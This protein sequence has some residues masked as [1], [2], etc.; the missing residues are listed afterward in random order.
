MTC[1][2]L[3]AAP[4]AAQKHKQTAIVHLRTPRRCITAPLRLRFVN[5]SADRKVLLR[6]SQYLTPLHSIHRLLSTPGTTEMIV[7]VSDGEGCVGGDDARGDARP[8]SVRLKR[9]NHGGQG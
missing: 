1:D 5:C 7:V 6:R 4:I 8:G 3:C 2:V 9:A